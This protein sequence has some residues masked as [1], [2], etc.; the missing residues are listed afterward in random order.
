MAQ[1]KKQR[2]KA[3]KR[4]QKTT[5]AKPPVPKAAASSPKSSGGGKRKLII[6]GAALAIVAGV[7]ATVVLVAN[8]FAGHDGGEASATPRPTASVGASLKPTKL[9]AS[10]TRAAF[11]KD[12]R[13]S[14]DAETAQKIADSCTTGKPTSGSGRLRGAETAFEA[15]CTGTSLKVINAATKAEIVPAG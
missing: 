3:E 10:A 1:T 14:I 7:L 6:G 13:I 11:M 2:F 15:T 8:P 4:V 12:Y 5:A 9:D